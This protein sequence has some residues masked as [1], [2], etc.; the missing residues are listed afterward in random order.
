MTK[1][2]AELNTEI[3]RE[4]LRIFIKSHLK[5]KFNINKRYYYL[6]FKS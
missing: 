1:N 3:L 4:Y 2:Y 5:L 6:S